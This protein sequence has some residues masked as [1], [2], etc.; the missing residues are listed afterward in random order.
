MRSLLIALALA[1]VSSGCD[2]ARGTPAPPPAEAPV[3]E[4]STLPAAAPPPTASA[5]ETAGDDA[6]PKKA[7]A[8]GAKGQPTCPM[9]GWMKE[10]VAKSVNRADLKAIADDLAFIAKHPVE[11]YDE[12]VKIAETGAEAARNDDLSGARNACKGCHKLYQ[13]RYK[14]ERR[15][16]PWP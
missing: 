12:W 8:C 10:H 11:G 16:A 4:A 7:Y 15:D 1:A 9:Q 13:R 2:D 3:A 14:E 5:D 6:A